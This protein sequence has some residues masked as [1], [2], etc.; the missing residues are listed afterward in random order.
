MSDCAQNNHINCDFN[1]EDERE[2]VGKIYKN[3]IETLS[4][5]DKPRKF[6]GKRKQMKKLKSS[7]SG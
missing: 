3:A 4:A 2:S 7:K 6:N 1:I 5:N